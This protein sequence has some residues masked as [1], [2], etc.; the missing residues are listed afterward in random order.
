MAGSY[1]GVAGAVV[2][3]ALGLAAGVK[4]ELKTRAGR[5]VGGLV[6]GALGTALGTAAGGLGYRP[7][8]VMSRETSGFS[9]KSL[10]SRLLNTHYTSHPK[11]SGTIVDEGMAHAR[12]GDLI[13]TNDDGDF[14]LEILQKLIGCRAHWTHN[15]LV[16]SDGTVMDILLTENKPTRWPLEVAF[17]DNC[18]AKILRPRYANPENLEKTLAAA[19]AR[20]ERMTYDFRFDLKTD[21]AQY[22]Q[23]YAYKALKEGAPEIR[24]EPRF[25]IFR[26]FVSADEFEASPDLEEVWSTGSNFWINWLSHYT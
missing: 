22:C 20:F 6:G 24:I 7:S 1:L 11:L 21:D 26:D 8:E 3:G 15:Y 25:R 5:L 16:D 14:M 9:L 10:P 4:L 23:E 2:G 19:R 18:H 17:K 13:I 12:P